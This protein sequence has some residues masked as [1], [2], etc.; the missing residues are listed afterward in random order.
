I[1]TVVAQASVPVI[2]TGVGNVHVYVDSRADHAQAGPII[3][4]SKTQRVG[5]CNAAE[6]L[7]GH[8]DGADELLPALYAALAEKDVTIH[9]D[10]DASRA[11]AS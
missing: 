4:N 11:A 2:E 9:A 10:D 8:R 5:V 7:L 6:S 3:L 1:Q